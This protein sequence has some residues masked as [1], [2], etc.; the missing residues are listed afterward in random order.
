M[1]LKYIIHY[2]SLQ[3]WKIPLK[4]PTKTRTEPVQATIIDDVTVEVSSIPTE[5]IR[6][7][8][9]FSRNCVLKFVGEHDFLFLHLTTFKARFLHLRLEIFLHLWLKKFLQL[10]VIFSN[11]VHFF[12]FVVDL[13]IMNFFCIC[14]CKSPPSQ[15]MEFTVIDS[16]LFLR[17]VQ[18]ALFY[19]VYSF[20]I[21]KILIRLD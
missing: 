21:D 5:L 6:I 1:N 2:G 7:P 12:T 13:Y 8:S 18:S 15:Y 4:N 14:G 9:K 16:L 20:I 17:L 3:Y 19:S 11:E 10:R